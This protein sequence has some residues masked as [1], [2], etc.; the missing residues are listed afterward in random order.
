M[1]NQDRITIDSNLKYYGFI[2][3]QYN[4]HLMGIDNNPRIEWKSTQN[5]VAPSFLK[6]ITM[7]QIGPGTHEKVIRQMYSNLL[8]ELKENGNR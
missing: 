1:E 8:T 5:F 3:T 2:P 7:K 6:K 4:A